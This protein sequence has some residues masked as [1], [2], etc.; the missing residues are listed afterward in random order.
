MAYVTLQEAKEHLLIEPEF[1]SD[2]TKIESLIAVAEDKVA[3]ELCITVPE[4]A[5][6]GGG[7]EVPPTIKQAILLQV[8]AYYRFREDVTTAQTHPLVGGVKHL[9]GLFRDYTL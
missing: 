8:G 6:L 2:D 4:L 1:T 3:R 5:T 9:I 7:T